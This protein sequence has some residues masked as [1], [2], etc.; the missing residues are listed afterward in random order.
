MP[1]HPPLDPGVPPRKRSSFCRLCLSTCF[2]LFGFFVAVA[3][4]GVANALFQMTQFSHSRVFQNQTLNEVKDR[5]AVV[6]PLVDG[7]QTFDIAVSVWAAS[8]GIDDGKSEFDVSETP[9]FSDIVF[10]ELH[11]VDKHISVNLTYQ[12]PI[13]IFQRLILKENDL[14]ASFVLIP[15]VP[16]LVNQ[17]TNFSTWRPETLKI[18]SVRS[19]PFPLGAADHGPQSIA[20]RALDSFGISMPML[21]FHEFGSKCTKSEPI[22]ETDSADEVALSDGNNED[23]EEYYEEQEQ[24]QKDTTGEPPGVSDISK[25]PEHASKRHPFVVTRYVVQLWD[26]P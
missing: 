11:L 23:D 5:A 8:A 1:R 22:L 3:I 26:A 19:W 18:S 6:R 12:L 25:Y 20:D 15:T 24:V 17:I 10:Q 13:S 7:K 2:V 9:L 16:S 4:Y 21:E 14:R